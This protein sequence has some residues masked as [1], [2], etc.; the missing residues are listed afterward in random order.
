MVSQRKAPA[1]PDSRTRL[2]AAATAEFAAHGFD[3]TTVDRIAARAR[4]NKAMLYYHFHD[5]TALYR[6]ILLDV[7]QGVAAALAASA[8]AADPDTRLRSFI[9][10]VADQAVNRPHFPVMWLREMADGG[11]HIDGD[12]VVEISRILETLGTILEAGVTAGVFRPAHPLVVQMN[13]VGPLLVFAA[14]ATARARFARTVRGPLVVDR[15]QVLA[16]VE[17]ATLAALRP[18]PSSSVPVSP[19]R[20]RR[21]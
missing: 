16:H 12:V 19:A 8:P 6:A 3:G 10:T 9:H 5:K 14:T 11:R 17:A 18:L 4:L 13:I 2:L 21:S 1:R 7:F 15:D 20:R